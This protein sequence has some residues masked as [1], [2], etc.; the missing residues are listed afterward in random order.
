MISLCR[1]QI[2]CIVEEAFC[3]SGEE[4]RLPSQQ[5]C[6]APF[7]TKSFMT[8]RGR[9]YALFIFKWAAKSF[10]LTSHEGFLNLGGC[11]NMSGIS[12]SYIWQIQAGL[13]R[14]TTGGE[15]KK[16]CIP[17][18]ETVLEGWGCSFISLYSRLVG[19]SYFASV[20]LDH[21]LHV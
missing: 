13:T 9:D 3:V 1:R 5:E 18:S 17:H 6:T 7:I 14:H 12:S 4:V 15:G 20:Q 21:R 19:V 11:C 2:S 16:K 8:Q 10:G